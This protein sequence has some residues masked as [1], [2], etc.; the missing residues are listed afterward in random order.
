[1]AIVA[2]S[3]EDGSETGVNRETRGFGGALRAIFGRVPGRQTGGPVGARM[4]YI[5]GERGPE[6]FI[7]G[8][9][10]FV[11]S[12]QNLRRQQ[13]QTPNITQNFINN[14]VD[15]SRERQRGIIEDAGLQALAVQQQLERQ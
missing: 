5:V 15:F 10:G 9:A 2:T 1:M 12:N 6:L 14:G 8:Q 4:P 7:P 11:Q 13:S 3:F